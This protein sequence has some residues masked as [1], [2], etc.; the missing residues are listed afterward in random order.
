MEKETSD[1][2]YNTSE[3][4]EQLSKRILINKHNSRTCDQKK[5]TVFTIQI[6]NNKH[7]NLFLLKY[8]L[9]L[10]KKKSTL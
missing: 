2:T 3:S 4:H 1:R 7:S 5:P 8:S 9:R 6:H 10:K